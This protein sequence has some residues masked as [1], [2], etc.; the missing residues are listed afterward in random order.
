MALKAVH[1][2][3]AELDALPEAVRTL[4]VARDGKFYLDAEGVDYEGKLKGAL[5]RERGESG[6][7]TKQL[8]DLTAKLGDLDPEKA[9]EAMRQLQE[10]TSQSELGEVPEALRATVEKIIAKRTERM[11][12]DHANQVKA[13]ET[14]LKTIGSERE[15]L[16]GTLRSLQLNNGIRSLAAAKGVKAEHVE[17]VIARF[18]ML[19]VDGVKWDFDPS[20]PE[21]QQ[22][23]AK[24]ADGTVAYG[25]DP[26]KPMSFEEGF[27]ILSTKV[28][29]FFMPNAGSGAQNQGGARMQ[30]GTMTITRADARDTHKYQAARAEAAKLGVPLQI[31]QQ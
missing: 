13:F 6:R 9:R 22:I 24:R 14:Q 10:L 5:E 20:K 25:K 21:G 2:S 16:S 18:T 26:Q 30:G 31:E 4:Y 19:G 12:T 7:L 3:Q 27:E 15:Q 17:D 23:I 11:Q 1:A 8:A 28:P 29:G